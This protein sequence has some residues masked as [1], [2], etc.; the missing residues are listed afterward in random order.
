M[1]HHVVSVFL[2]LFTGEK[3]CAWKNKHK[4]EIRTR[5]LIMN[6]DN[7]KEDSL[8]LSISRS[9]VAPRTSVSL[10]IYTHTIRSFSRV[11][12]FVPRR[13][14]EEENRKRAR[15]RFF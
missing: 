13:R 1:F 4:E 12:S 9:R 11:R 2:R 14:G 6:N 15:A 5:L 8:S 7:N 3:T 10:Y